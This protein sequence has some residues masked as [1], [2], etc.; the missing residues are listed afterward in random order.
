MKVF[1]RNIHLYLGLAAGLIISIVCL[2]GAILVFEI[3]LQ[4]KLNPERY[5][6]ES[7]DKS[8]FTI[9]QLVENLKKKNPEAKINGAKVY[10]DPYRTVEISFGTKPKEEKKAQK[11][12]KESKPEAREGERKTAFFNK[13]TG[14]LIEIYSYR[15]S[16]F[17]TVFST[18]RWLLA[19]AVGKLIVGISSLL[20]L[21]ILITGIILWWP[22]SNRILKQRL[23]LKW[24]TGFKRLNHDLHVVLGF[25][26]AIFLF[27]F[28]F[29]GLAWS[30]EWFNK[31]IYKVTQ[32]EMVAP[33][34]I[35]SAVVEEKSNVNF[36]KAFS[37]VY[38]NSKNAVYYNI[39]KPK[40]SA[41]TFSVNVLPVNMY[42]MQ[43]ETYYIDQYTG[44]IVEKIAFADKNTGQQVR[45]SFKPVHT[46]SIFGLPSKIIGL[47][48]CVLGFT[49]PITGTIMWLNRIRKRK[50]VTI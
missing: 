21:F 4:Q 37:I 7:I 47:V 6:V 43:T 44:E 24:N 49:F 18:H 50:L 42:E 20:F 23:K 29:T 22:K 28:A 15:D 38:K 1:F 41:G 45:A 3:E 14:E 16:F 30:F 32:S 35:Q 12:D 46:A 5:F 26:A 36:E 27:V 19:G 31:G 8:Y 48:V 13:Y 39:S 11:P 9:D 33:P 10:A 17:Y 34:V 2:T 25:Y 40:D